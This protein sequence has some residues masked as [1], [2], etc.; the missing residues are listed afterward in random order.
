MDTAETP[1]LL[2]RWWNAE[3]QGVNAESK[4][5]AGLFSDVFQEYFT[6]DSIAG[7]KFQY[8]FENHVRINHTPSPFISTFKSAL[9]PIHRAL[10]EEEGA[11]ISI[12]DTKRLKTKVYSSLEY[13]RQ[14]KV[15][16][17]NSNYNG[18]GEYLVWGQIDDAIICTF[19]ITTLRRISRENTDISQLLQLHKIAGSKR[20]RRGLHQAIAKDAI[21]LDKKAGATVGKLLS[22]L[23]V[24]HEYIGTMSKGIAYSWRVK[25]RRTP[26]RDFFEGVELGYRGELVILSPELSPFLDA[27]NPDGDI[28]SDSDIYSLS[29]GSPDDDDVPEA[30]DSPD[31]PDSLDE[32]RYLNK[33]GSYGTPSPE[34][35]PES[36]RSVSIVE[37]EE[38]L[39]TQRMNASFTI[40][41]GDSSDGE[42]LDLFD[43]V[44]LE[45][46]QITSDLFASERAW[47]R[48]ALE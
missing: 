26:W 44:I 3:S 33:T 13:M 14:W 30:S 15:K 22:L 36:E 7:D 46:E 28:G 45:R 29:E 21:Y 31:S 35:R 1:P 18:A 12:I 8:L 23:E 11:S 20:N 34:A 16:V 10:R 38:A 24:P 48:S 6:P 4:F 42:E 5:V 37:F 40:D 2:Y 41:M 9:A 27:H 32:N 43:G 17:K 25:T 47:V 19:K 39:V